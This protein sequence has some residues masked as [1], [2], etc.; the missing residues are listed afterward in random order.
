MVSEEEPPEYLIK[1][2]K[3]IDAAFVEWLTE[4]DGGP[5]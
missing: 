1:T 5:Q 3:A 2:A 4:D